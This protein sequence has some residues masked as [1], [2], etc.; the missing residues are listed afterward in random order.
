MQ[1]ESPSVNL[2][3]DVKMNCILPHCFSHFCLRSYLLLTQQ[4]IL[5]KTS[6]LLVRGNLFS[7]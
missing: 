6:F 3:F 5:S 1:V 7:S 2:N 4:A